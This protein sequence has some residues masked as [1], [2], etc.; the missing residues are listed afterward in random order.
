M[1]RSFRKNLA[2]LGALATTL[3]SLAGCGQWPSSSQSSFLDSSSQPSWVHL[4][5]LAGE[6]G[7]ILGEVNQTVLLGESGTEV[8]ASPFEGYEFTEWSDHFLS[9]TRV[10]DPVVGDLTLTATFTFIGQS[11]LPTIHIDTNNVEIASDIDYTPATISVE[12]LRVG[13]TLPEVSGGIRLRGHSTQTMPKKPYRIKFDKKQSLFGKTAA[14]SWVLLADYFD[15][16]KMHNYTAFTL[17]KSLDHTVY[18]PM[19][20]HIE[21]YLNDVYQGLYLLTE[22][23]DEKEGRADLVQEIFPSTTDYNFLVAF[24]NW[25][26]MD[27]NSGEIEGETYFNV[28][29]WG[30]PQSIVIKYPE[31]SDF[32]SDLQYYAFFNWLKDYFED[33]VAA[34]ESG[35][36]ANIANRIDAESLTDI[37]LVDQI[38]NEPDHSFTSY[39]MSKRVG[40]KLKFGPT[41]DYDLSLGYDGWLG[42]PNNEYNLD[43]VNNIRFNNFFATQ[44]GQTVE[45]RNML[46]DRW[47]EVGNGAMSAYLSE[48]DDY[49]SL[50]IDEVYA[51]A[52]AWKYSSYALDYTHGLCADNI[53]YLK[54]WLI[55]RQAALNYHY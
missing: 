33:L 1:T 45:G 5:Y 51:D 42:Y 40:E 28:N 20:Q 3:F 32:P 41:W 55:Q 21:V 47:N 54:I 12:S 52:D 26:R 23:V 49:V 43:Q 10:D 27:W 4:S 31:K 34:F 48:F 24:D 38:M 36:Y 8:I 53:A 29:F 35:V 15:P 37:T 14:K 18:Q 16:S 19:A 44:F 13:Q 6:G 39:Y 46:Y 22:Q 7:E 30:G 9:A 25:A 2:F 50:I 17:G 11:I